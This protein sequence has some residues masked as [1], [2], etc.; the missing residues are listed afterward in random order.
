[1]P[2]AESRAQQKEQRFFPL[3]KAQP[4]KSHGLFATAVSVSSSSL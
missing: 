3:A 1:M 2:W 4:V